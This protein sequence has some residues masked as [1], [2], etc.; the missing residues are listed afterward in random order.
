MFGQKDSWLVRMSTAG[1]GR[2]AM[3]TKLIKTSLK[4]TPIV[5][6]WWQRWL[7]FSWRKSTAMSCQ[8]Q[9]LPPSRTHRGGSINLPGGRR[10]SSKKCIDSK[11][12]LY[13]WS[14]QVD[15][16]LASNTQMSNI[17]IQGWGSSPQAPSPCFES[18]DSVMYTLLYVYYFLHPCLE[19]KGAKPGPE[20][21]Q[22]LVK[23]HIHQTHFKEITREVLAPPKW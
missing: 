16:C 4:L 20:D 5:L 15:M 11:F 8:N 7:I 19:E 6:R 23:I 22:I 14:P 10:L 17:H 13:T 2:F 1:P 18:L 3:L 21:K 9:T 12:I